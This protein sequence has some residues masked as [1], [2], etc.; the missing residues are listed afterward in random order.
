MDVKQGAKRGAVAARTDFL[1]LLSVNAMGQ[2][3]KNVDVDDE[4]DDAD[5]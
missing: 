2:I 4:V 3:V 5:D 1:A